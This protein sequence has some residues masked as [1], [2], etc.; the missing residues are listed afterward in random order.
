MNPAEEERQIGLIKGRLSVKFPGAT[1]EV[2]DD[3]VDEA[4]SHFSG[5]NIRDFVPLLVERRANETLTT[6]VA[7]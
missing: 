4:Y 6:R 5:K 7:T 3:A 2:V 1:R